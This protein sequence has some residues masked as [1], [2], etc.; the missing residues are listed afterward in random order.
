MEIRAI[1][2]DL[3]KLVQNFIDTS[4]AKS[5]AVSASSEKEKIAKQDELFIADFVQFA[6][7]L[8]DTYVTDSYADET[9]EISMA[10]KYASL[11]PKF[12]ARLVAPML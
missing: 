10:S 7:Y 11:A 2:P 5:E 4:T 1:N 8:K 9:S 6:N 3:E 12:R